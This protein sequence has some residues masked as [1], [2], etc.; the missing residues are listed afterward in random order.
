M[1]IYSSSSPNKKTKETNN[2]STNI[3]EEPLFM[4][5]DITAKEFKNM[6]VN[7]LKKLNP[8][9]TIQRIRQIKQKIK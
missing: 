1:A 4:G 3:Q 5:G 7:E 2:K 6:S 9:L 8:D